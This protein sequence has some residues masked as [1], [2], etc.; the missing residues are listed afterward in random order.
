MRLAIRATT[1]LLAA[2]SLAAC[3]GGDEATGPDAPRTSVPAELVGTWFQGSVSNTDYY[4]PSTGSWAGPSGT[5]VAYTFTANG[6][7]QHAGVL[8][9]SLYGCTSIV[10]GWD[11]GAVAVRGT[12][13]TLTATSGRLKSE[14]NCVAEYNYDKSIAVDPTVVTYEVGV[15]DYGT[16][17]LWLT[18]PD[19]QTLSFRRQE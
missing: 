11:R 18:W 7:Y 1:T 8:Q 16:E 15:D 9:S 6:E 3:G 2:L 13:V 19:G 14:D 4:N 17:T 12:E 10:F 5:G